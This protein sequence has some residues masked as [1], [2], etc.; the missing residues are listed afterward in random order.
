MGNKVAVIGGGASGLVAAINAA[1]NGAYT[2][3]LEKNDRVGK[4]IL[5]TGNGRCNYTNINAKA[6]DYNSDFVSFALKEFP[7]RKIIEF[8]EEIGV[9]AK[10][11][12]EG[13]VY[14]MSC[15]ASAVLDVLRAEAIRL[16]V[17]IKTEFCV[18]SVERKNGGF[19]VISG[20]GE[21]VSA[22]KVIFATGGFASPKSG[23]DG[24]GAKILKKLGHTLTELKPSLCPLLTKKGIH[25]VR[26][27]GRVTL[28]GTYSQVG[29]IQFNK[30]NISGI[31]VFN[32]AKYATVGDCISVDFMPEYS[33]EHVVDILSKRPVQTME[34][35][36]VGLLN[37]NLSYA[38]L[39]DAGISPLSIMSDTLTDSQ[40]CKIAKLLKGWDF[41]IS[42]LVSWDNCQVTKGGITL[43]EINAGTM[44]SRIVKGLYIVGE[45]CDVDS[46]CGGFN[47][48]WAW[49]S[50]LLAGREAAKCIE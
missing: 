3:V 16:G 1:R 24:S 49:A 41:D 13:R 39:K 9:L 32:I 37:K 34:T 28:N 42:G 19:T 11:E 12:D 47:L 8:F 43:A 25:G 7:P 10:I 22:D 46:E 4:K 44:E 6:E 14:P 17:Y 18:K 2:V 35:F 20:N 21:S 15:Q 48:Q 45:L 38:L 33:Q 36:L 30:D 50:G 5:A 27:Y 31:P 23:S 29:E 40:L 26:Q